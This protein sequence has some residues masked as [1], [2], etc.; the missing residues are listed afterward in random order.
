MADP[1]GGHGWLLPG[2]CMVALGGH[3]WLL[4]GGMHGIQRDTEI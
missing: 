3:A 2:G 1:W 4:P